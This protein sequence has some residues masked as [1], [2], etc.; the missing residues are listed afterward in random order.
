MQ[1]DLNYRG[2]CIPVTSLNLRKVKQDLTIVENS[3]DFNRFLDKKTVK[4]YWSSKGPN[5]KT[6]LYVPREYGFRKYG[7]IE[8]GYPHVKK[9]NV[10]FVG[11]L[12]PDQVNI[13]GTAL[14]TLRDP[15]KGGGIINKTTGGGKTCMAM[16]IISQ[17]GVK[18]I[19][20]VN[21][22]GEMIKTEKAIKQFLPNA[23]VG[24]IQ[25]PKFE[26]D[27][28]I[29]IATIQ[30]L[31]SRYDTY[32]Y[33][34]FYDIGLCIFDEVHSTSPGQEY[35]KI[36]KKLQT[37]YRLGL[38]ATLR[39]D[40]FSQVYL[41]QIGPVIVR[42]K[43]VSIVPYVKVKKIN[44]HYEIPMN[45][46][47]TMNY[48]KLISELCTM[49]D[50]NDNIADI[51]IDTTENNGNRRKVIVFTH[52]VTHCKTLTNLLQKK[53]SNKDIVVRPYYGQLKQDERDLALEADIMVATFKLASQAFDHPPLDTIVFASPVSISRKKNGHGQFYEE[54]KLLEQSIGRI[55]R[56]VNSNF[57]LVV[58]IVDINGTPDN[59]YFRTHYYKRRKF[60]NNMGYNFL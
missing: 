23:K 36:L 4:L 31:T 13:V 50:R 17:L 59:E 14:L 6:W 11:E 57:P 9:I 19:F 26:T 43:H 28:D 49:N 21:M 37:K 42:D 46:R 20:I 41:E 5:N 45:S 30:T 25:G 48:T 52:R 18:T 55:L 7:F 3:T 12:R 2:Y 47:G 44:T 16:N 1:K 35:N 8:Y 53:V 40:N 29:I 34:D 33:S 32:N 51:I 10:P 38:T 54:T 15:K 22:V 24:T 27:A 58:D 39:K 56:R 60:Y